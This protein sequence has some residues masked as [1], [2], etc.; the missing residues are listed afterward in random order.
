[1]GQLMSRHKKKSDS[2]I[3]I[4]MGIDFNTPCYT[5]DGGASL[6]CVRTDRMMDEDHLNL[7]LLHVNRF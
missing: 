7:L 5:V 6:M 1:M 2:D 4:E 3:D